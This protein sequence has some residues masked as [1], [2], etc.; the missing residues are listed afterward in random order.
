MGDQPKNI[1]TQPTDAD[2]QCGDG[3]REG[4]R[5]GWRWTK[6]GNGDI[7]NSVNNNS[8][9]LKELTVFAMWEVGRSGE[10]G[11][12]LGAGLVG[13]ACRQ[14][15]RGLGSDRARV[16]EHRGGERGGGRIPTEAWGLSRSV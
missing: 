16:L 2:P 6:G 10:Q 11:P 5:A 14:V 7:C 4:G 12:S 13:G 3:H 8:K 9:V 1:Y 15:Q